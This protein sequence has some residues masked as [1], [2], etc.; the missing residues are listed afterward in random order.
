MI[1]IKGAILGKFIWV[2]LPKTDPERKGFKRRAKS[3]VKKMGLEAILKQSG[4][5]GRKK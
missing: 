4:K 2:K 3:V 5:K 1:N